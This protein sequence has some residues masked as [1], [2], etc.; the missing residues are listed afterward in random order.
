MEGLTYQLKQ[1]HTKV[2][3]ASCFFSVSGTYYYKE[4]L[5]RY[6]GST[7]LCSYRGVAQEAPGF[8]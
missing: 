7:H 8:S 2:E 3:F 1:S 4:K 5:N 6:L